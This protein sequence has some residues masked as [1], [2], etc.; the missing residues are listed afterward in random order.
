M[1]RGEDSLTSLTSFVPQGKLLILPISQKKPRIN[2]DFFSESRGEDSNLRRVTPRVLQ[3]RTIVHSVTSGIPKL[4]H[5]CYTF[6][7]CFLRPLRVKSIN[8][9]EV[10]LDN[11]I[12]AYY[13]KKVGILKPNDMVMVYG[14]LILEKISQKNHE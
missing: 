9:K 6:F 12:K 10:V 5:S 3:T 1:S 2:L 14:N 7:M 4:Y 11:G 8:G 13:E